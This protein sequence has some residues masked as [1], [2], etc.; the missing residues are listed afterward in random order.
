VTVELQIRIARGRVL[1]MLEDVSRGSPVTF[2]ATYIFQ[3]I[4]ILISLA[5]DI[6]F[7]GF[8]LFHAKSSG[9]RSGGFRIHN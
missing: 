5:T 3:S 6:A 2:D 7:V 4:Q 1:P 8:L 9:V